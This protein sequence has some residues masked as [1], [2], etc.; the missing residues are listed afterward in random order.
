[1]TETDVFTFKIGA[2]AGQKITVYID[3]M[4]ANALGVDTLNVNDF[5]TTHFD[6]QLESI[7]TAI[8]NVSIQRAKL[9]AV[10]NRLEHTIN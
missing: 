4:S 9:G 8:N 10:Q 1:G 2:N 5:A 3:S 7:D 6:T